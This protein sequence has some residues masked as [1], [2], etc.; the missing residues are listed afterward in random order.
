M[1]KEQFGGIVRALLAGVAGYFV[2]KGYD[3]ALIN[4]IAGAAGVIVVAGWSIWAK[5]QTPPAA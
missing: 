4:E 2:G 3:A 1:T 5:K